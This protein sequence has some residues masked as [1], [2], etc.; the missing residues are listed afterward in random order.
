MEKD[1]KDATEIEQA[2]AQMKSAKSVGKLMFGSFTVTLIIG[3][4]GSFII[5]ALL[6]KESVSSEE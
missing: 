2:I 4:V 1:N 6:K 3:M 5:A